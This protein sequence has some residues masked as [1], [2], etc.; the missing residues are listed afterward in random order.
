MKMAF[1]R[2]TVFAPATVANV[3]AGFDV[4]GIAVEGPGDRIVAQ[5]LPEPGAVIGEITGVVTELPREPERNTASVAATS[6]LN[7][8]GASEIG[9]RLDLEK[10]I[11]LGSGMGGSAA[12]SVAAVVAVNQLLD[13]PLALDDLLQHAALGEEVASGAPHVDNAAPSL[14]GGMVAVVGQSPPRIARVPLPDWLRIALVRPHVTVETRAA[15]AVLP[16]EIPL[17][18]HVEQAQLLSGLLIACFQDDVDLMRQSM[19]DL[20]AE[21]AR[22]SLIPGYVAARASAIEAGA[23]GVGIGGAGPTLFAWCESDEIAAQVAR[24]VAAAFLDAGHE[25]T[26]NISAP[27]TEGAVVELAS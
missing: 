20:I 17:R 7:A 15:R 3:A 10:G 21:P 18:L 4:L 12:S 9:V 26:S 5:R 6:L 16:V 23:I 2:V 19:R 1:D 27:R 8:V 25:S 13:Q 14:F 11:P 24:D 22:A